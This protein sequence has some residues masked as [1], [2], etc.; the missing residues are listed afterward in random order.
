MSDAIAAKYEA[1]WR[2]RN[3][4]EVAWA[5][6]EPWNP[7]AVVCELCSKR[8]EGCARIC[9]RPCECRHGFPSRA[10]ADQAME[11]GRGSRWPE[12]MTMVELGSASVAVP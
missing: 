1:M 9:V 10:A 12:E 5:Y 4:R 8:G 3:A 11:K 2:E 7:K 6:R